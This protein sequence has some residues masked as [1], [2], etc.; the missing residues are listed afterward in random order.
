M[1][2]VGNASE[3]VFDLNGTTGAITQ[4][5]RP[6]IPS[7]WNRLGIILYAAARGM[8]PQAIQAGSKG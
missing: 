1:D 3:W 8:I 6:I 7:I 2:L 4:T 5:S